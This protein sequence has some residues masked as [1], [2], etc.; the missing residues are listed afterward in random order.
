MPIEVNTIWKYIQTHLENK[1]SPD[2]YQSF[3]RPLRPVGFLNNTLLLEVPD[4]FYRQWV[5]RYLP[6]I[7]SS[8]QQVVNK[9]LTI[10]LLLPEEIPDN[11]LPTLEENNNTA[12]DYMPLNP[13]YTFDTF[14]VGNSNRFTHAACLAVADSPSQSYN[15]LFIY[16]GVGLGKTHLMQAIGHYIIQNKKNLKVCYVT[17]EKFTNELIEAI[18]NNKTNEFRNKYRTIDILLI[19][20]IQF[21]AGKESSQIEFFH[22]FNALYEVNKQIVIS[23]D[24]PPSEIEKLE[25]RLRSRFEWGLITDIQPPDFETRIAILR[26]K[27]QLEKVTIPDE[28]VYYIAERIESNIRQLEGALNRLLAYCRF[29]ECEPTIE[30]AEIALKNIIQPTPRQITI[31]DIQKVVAEHFKIRVDDLKSKKRTREIAFPRQ[32]AMYLTRKILDLSFPQIGSIFGGRDH[33]TVMHACNKIEVDSETDKDLKNL[34]DSL[35]H[36]IKNK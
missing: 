25:E 2:A 28:V 6:I 12:Y 3:I 34:I 11:A 10:E 4:E 16:G 18:M 22:T 35:I 19:D 31:E 27:I 32:I 15:P 29:H 36:K 1:M 17:S 8:L 30:A 7:C 20:D 9:Q 21:I 5:T 33:T 13:K 23:S 26:K 14:V 24:K